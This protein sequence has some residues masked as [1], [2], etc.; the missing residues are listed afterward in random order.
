MTARVCLHDA[1]A[2][3]CIVSVAIGALTARPATAAGADIELG[4]YLATECMTCHSATA[5]SG[6]PNIFGVDQA[7]LI[8]VIKA[9]REK[10]LPNPVMQNVA[11]RLSDEEIKSLALYFA[12][13]RKP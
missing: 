5:T 8:E 9:Y 10:A 6:I 13:T 12:T 11:G 1:P 7:H 4:R 3:A 2:I